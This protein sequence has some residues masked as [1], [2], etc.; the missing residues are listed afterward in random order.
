MVVCGTV[1]VVVVA[2]EVVEDVV[3]ELEQPAVLDTSETTESD[4]RP[5]VS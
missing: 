1:V 4:Q 2:C 5:P 3:E